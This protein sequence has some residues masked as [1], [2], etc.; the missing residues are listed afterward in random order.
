MNCKHQ[1]IFVEKIIRYTGFNKSILGEGSTNYP[2]YQEIY[3]FCCPICG[4][5]KEVNG[6][7]VIY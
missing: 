7:Q 2:V 3:R 1:F 5:I 6:N 4:E